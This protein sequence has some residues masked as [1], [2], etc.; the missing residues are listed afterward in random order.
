MVPGVDSETL[1]GI[2]YEWITRTSEELLHEV[3]KPRPVRRVYIPKHN[4]KLRPLGVGSPR[5]KVVQQAYKL[6]L[7][8]ILE[9]E[10]S[11]H[12]HGFR[13]KRG[14]HTALR[15]LRKWKGVK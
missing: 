15:E 2:S 6:V 4:G 10:F 11:K 13:P 8:T 9:P 7:E 1:D 5:D 14:C 3:Y 12:S